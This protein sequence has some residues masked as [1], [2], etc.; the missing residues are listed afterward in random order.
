[1]SVEWTDLQ[2]LSL[3]GATLQGLLALL[4]ALALVVAQRT[5]G[6]RTGGYWVAA[7]VSLAIALVAVIVGTSAVRTAP[8]DVSILL[9]ICNGAYVTGKL[10]FYACIA[11]GTAEMLGRAS[12]DAVRG[13]ILAVVLVI[14]SA[15]GLYTGTIQKTF[16]VQGVL[17]MVLMLGCSVALWRARPPFRTAASTLLALTTA[18]YGLLALPYLLGWRYANVQGTTDFWQLAIAI[19]DRGSLPDLFAQ[20]LM[21]LT[22]VA[23]LFEQQ[24]MLTQRSGAQQSAL[25]RE[26]M[27]AERLETLG[28]V[29]ATVAHELNNPLSVVLGTAEHLLA[30]QGS[31]P[32]RD[33]LQLMW[34]E[35]MRCRHVARELLLFSRDQRP[36]VGACDAN[37]I[38]SEAVDSVRLHAA[39]GGVLLTS[40]TG[41][42]FTLEAEEIALQQVLI[43]LLRNAIDATP[44]GRS[45]V[46]SVTRVGPEAIFTIDDEGP[47]LSSEA[48]RRLADPF[49]TTKAA[50]QGSGLGLTIVKGIIARHNG[51]LDVESQPS[52]R[53]GCRFTVRIPLVS[54]VAAPSDIADGVPS[55]TEEFRVPPSLMPAVALPQEPLAHRVLVIDDEVGIR[56]VLARLLHRHGV[57][58]ELAG[59]GIEARDAIESRGEG[60]WS[61]IFCDVR[62]PREDGVEFTAWLEQR[63]PALLARLVL[64]TGDTVNDAVSAVAAR[65]GCQLMAKPFRQHDVDAMLVKLASANAPPVGDSAP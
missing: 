6:S 54:P 41:A 19:V 29:T 52:S 28:R 25:R 55:A 18:F 2:V 23:L 12:T 39:S 64:L 11:L 57:Q 26:M 53:V 14:G 58:V 24:R 40:R 47:G 43:N 37:A 59:D 51:R 44:R 63:H 21:G 20:F 8:G 62:M 7:Q 33:D 22:T 17:G 38:L 5:T 9:H 60:S 3:V 13:S 50:G 65:T 48:R 30:T 27:T 56:R 16:P 34:R 35:A 45:V 49:F 31:G 10:A 42:A 15:S 4:T 32:V 46:A 61:A 1:M 36:P